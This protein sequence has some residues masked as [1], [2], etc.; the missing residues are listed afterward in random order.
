MEPETAEKIRVFQE[1]IARL[2]IENQ[3]LIDEEM[4]ISCNGG[5]QE[6]LEKKGWNINMI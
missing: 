5:E 2:E 3:D 1:E 6:A 4:D